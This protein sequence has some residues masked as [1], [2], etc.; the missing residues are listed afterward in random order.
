[1]SL[2]EGRASED[3]CTVE[4]SGGIRVPTPLRL[5]AGRPVIAG[6]RPEN[7]ELD[8]EGPIELK[9][10][11]VEVLGAD[12]IAHLRADGVDLPARLPRHQ[13]VRAGEMVRIS[14]QPGDV[15]LFDPETGHAI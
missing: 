13:P 7:V 10:D 5:A 3:G 15:R 14:I 2:L 8:P 11:L 9:T 12:Q 4:L 1:M 6:I